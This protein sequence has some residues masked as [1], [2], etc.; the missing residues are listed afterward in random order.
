MRRTV[1]ALL[2]FALSWPA[3][4]EYRIIPYGQ[5]YV[6][7]ITLRTA[8]VTSFSSGLSLSS[9][10]C[11]ISKAGG[12]DANCATTPTAIGSSKKYAVTIGSTEATTAYLAIHL[13]SGSSA[14]FG[15]EFTFDTCGNPSARF[16]V[17]PPNPQVV[18]ASGTC[19]SGTSQTCVD[20]A[21][22]EADNYWVNYTAIIISGQARCITGF[23]NST[24][25]LSW[26]PSPLVSGSASGLV[27]T[28]I[29]D[30]NCPN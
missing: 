19:S 16:L 28:L 5:S 11:K 25:T 17:C 6:F 3:L 13:E 27:Y 22:T 30:A 20:A 9:T 14:F 7:E 24:H 2:A 18:V 12:A 23:T 1:C 15:R 29:A 26:A 8:D 4:A 21:R 10:D